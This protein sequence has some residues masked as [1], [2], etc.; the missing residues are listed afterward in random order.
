MGV[1]V[2]WVGLDWA[3]VQRPHIKNNNN[4]LFWP[5]LFGQIGVGGVGG[6]AAGGHLNY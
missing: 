4:K 2:G 1:W 5:N 6:G 3:G